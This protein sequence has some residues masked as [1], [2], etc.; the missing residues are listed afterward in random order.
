MNDRPF[1]KSG[2][3]L[4]FAFVA[5]LSH[6]PI[7]G[8]Y[9]A[10]ASSVAPPPNLKVAFIGDTGNSDSFQQVLQLIKDEGADIVLHQ[11]DFDYVNDPA[12]WVQAFRF[13]PPWAITMM[14]CGTPVVETLEGATPSTWSPG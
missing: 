13:S 10:L 14:L 12:S 8:I 4:I 1:L 11:G 6:P 2:A 7:E 3:F 9:V 5:F